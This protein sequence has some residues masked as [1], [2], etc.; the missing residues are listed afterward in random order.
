MLAGTPGRTVG[1]DLLDAG[2]PWEKYKTTGEVAVQGTLVL[3]VLMLLGVLVL[4]QL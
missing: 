4:T 1:E 3:L 2:A